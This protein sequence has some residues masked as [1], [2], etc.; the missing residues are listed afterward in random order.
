MVPPGENASGVRD[1][2]APRGSGPPPAL[3]RPQRGP[4]TK[5]KERGKGKALSRCQGCPAGAPGCREGK[6][7]AE[8]GLPPAPGHLRRTGNE[9]KQQPKGA[10]QGFPPVKLTCRLALIP[11]LENAHGPG[12][13][14]P[15]AFAETERA[16]WSR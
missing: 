14:V 9:T 7:R 6:P 3:G 2:P 10:L 12:D 15:S 5:A 1:P 4:T 13:S 8:T 11:L 16:R